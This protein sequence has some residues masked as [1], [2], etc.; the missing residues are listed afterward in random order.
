[1]R[2]GLI[3]EF[4]L[5]LLM[6]LENFYQKKNLDS[7]TTQRVCPT[8]AICWPSWYKSLHICALLLHWASSNFVTL[9]RCLSYM[10]DQDHVHCTSWTSTLEVSYAIPSIHK[11]NSMLNDLSLV[12]LN[13][14]ISYQNKKDGML[15]KHDPK[16]WRKKL[17]TWNSKKKIY[18][19]IAMFSCYP[20]KGE[21]DS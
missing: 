9:V 15:K 3:E 14:G 20:N 10:F 17:D 1:M 21:R 4:L 6:C 12:S 13:W 8:K 5:Y 11:I 7:F 19:N 18:N 2:Y 16:K